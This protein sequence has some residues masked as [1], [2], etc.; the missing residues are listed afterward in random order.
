ML[1]LAHFEEADR[2]QLDNFGGGRGA[3]AESLWSQNFWPGIYISRSVHSH[4]WPRT[5]PLLACLRTKGA[6]PRVSIMYYIFSWLY[7]PQ[8]RILSSR[9]WNPLEVRWLGHEP[10]QIGSESLMRKPQGVYG[11]LLP[12]KDTMDRQPALKEGASPHQTPNLLCALIWD[13]S[14]SWMMRNKFLLFIS[15]QGHSLLPKQ[16]AQSMQG[17]SVSLFLSLCM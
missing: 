15:Q 9:K 14:V 16:T 8:S 7:L 3:Q 11:L 17:T 6:G 5:N 2:A 4:S 12:G 10:F 1:M 13:S